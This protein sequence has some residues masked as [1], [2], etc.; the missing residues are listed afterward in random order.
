VIDVI[1]RL[2]HRSAPRREFITV[3]LTSSEHGSYSGLV[4]GPIG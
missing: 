2:L 4:V 3:Y 1:S